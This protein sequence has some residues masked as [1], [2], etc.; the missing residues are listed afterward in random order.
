MEKKL[1]FSFEELFLLCGRSREEEPYEEKKLLLKLI[2]AFEETS[3][4]KGEATL[5][6]SESDLWKLRSY[7]DPNDPDF[8]GENLGVKLLHKIHTGLLEFNTQVETGFEEVK[9]TDY[10]KELVSVLA[11]Q[12]L[13]VAHAKTNE[14]SN[15]EEDSSTSERPSEGKGAES[16]EALSRPAGDNEKGD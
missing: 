10:R 16:P 5:S 14:N 15:E 8:E 3:E 13:E 12:L 4:T 11:R 1:A 9:G 7:V 2:S 6:L